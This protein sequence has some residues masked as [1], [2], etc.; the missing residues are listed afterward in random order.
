VNGQARRGDG[1]GGEHQAVDPV[2]QTAVAW[3]EIT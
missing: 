2:E 1:C 3:N